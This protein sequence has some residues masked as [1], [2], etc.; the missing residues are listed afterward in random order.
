MTCLTPCFAECVLSLPLSQTSGVF[1]FLYKIIKIPLIILNL[2]LYRLALFFLNCDLW[3][4]T[5]WTI[6][7]IFLSQYNMCM[8]ESLCHNVE[9]LPF[10]FPKSNVLCDLQGYWRDI[11]GIR[12]SISIFFP[13]KHVPLHLNITLIFVSYAICYN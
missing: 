8:V 13:T 10:A 4:G 11:Y 1:L 9:C 5:P 3:Y 6:K 7:G 12:V 2:L